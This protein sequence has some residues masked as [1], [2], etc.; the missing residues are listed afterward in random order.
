MLQK[1]VPK[2]SARTIHDIDLN[3]LWHKGI[4][5]L[6]VDLDNTLVSARTAHATP[7]VKHWLEH[8]QQHGFKIVIVS[9]NYKSR[10][11]KF[12]E[13][14]R[15]PFIY[16]A[17][18]PTLAAFHKALNL[19]GT[20][21]HQTAMIGDQLFTDVLGGNRVGLYTILVEPISFMEEAFPTKVNR[22][23]EKWIKRILKM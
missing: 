12:A 19:A 8:V 11:G 23:F 5:A 9:N 18:K 22:I 7:A 14:L 16:S 13:P 3:H 20:S 2:S 17:G 6:I 10:V 1:L 15:I 4:R 21:P